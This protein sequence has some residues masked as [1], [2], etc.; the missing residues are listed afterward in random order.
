MPGLTPGIPNPPFASEKTDFAPRF[1]VAF[2]PQPGIVMRGG[3]GIFYDTAGYKYLDQMFFNSPGYGGSEYDSPTYSALNGQ[4]PNVPYFT[5][6]N[7]FPTAVTLQKGEWPIPL[8]TLGGILAP[9]GDTTTID[10]DTSKTPYLQYWNLQLEKELGKVAV[11]SVGYVGSKGTR[12]PRPYDL[13]LP[14]QG[15]YLNSQDY[16]NARPL[17]AQYPN[18]FGAVN[19]VHH[20]LNNNYNAMEV[21]FRSRSWHNLVVISNYAW[22]K[23]LD[24]FYGTSAEAGINVI[25]G[26]WHPEWSYGP[27]DANHTHHFV[28]SATYSIPFLQTGNRLMRSTLG[29]WQLNAISTFES[30]SPF[31]IFN[32]STSSFDYMGDVPL[33]TCN[34]NLPR[35]QRTF[36]RALNTSCFTDP[37]AG[38]DGIAV[39]RGNAARNIITGPGISNWDMSAVKSISL[40]GE[41]SLQFRVEAFNALNHPQWSTVNGT[42]DT[43]TN[44]QS[45]FGYITASR[46]PR[47]LQLSGRFD[48]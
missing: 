2:R 45:T 4:D 1:G 19:A 6:G 42:D 15:V 9:Q 34:G 13:N 23:Q 36:L 7:T 40:A 29:G 32:G 43:L 37:A 33:R 12:L 17:S 10:K 44:Q 3:Y 30:G 38:P 16:F 21:E 18:R 31:T 11:F 46:P 26:Q 8:G 41:R 22:S 24:I 47:L 25:G 20:D 14:P 48:F 35:S 5:L 27:S 28:A 39:S